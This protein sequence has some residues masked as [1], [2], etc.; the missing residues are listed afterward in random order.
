MPTSATD[1]TELSA[2]AEL[3]RRFFLEEVSPHEGEHAE[4]GHPDRSLYR[5]AGELGLL[6]MSIPEQFGGGGGDFGHLALL[7]HEQITSGVTSLGL[8]ITEGI[9][10]HYLL[11]YATEEQKQ[12]WLPRLCSGQWVGSIAMTEPGT[13]SDLQAI[14]TRARLVGDEYLV[15]GA[16]TFITNGWLCDLV[17]IV[18]RT[19]ADTGASGISLLVAEISEDTPGFRRGRLLKKVG[20]KGQDTAELFFDG[21][22]IPAANMLGGVPGMGFYQLMEQLPQERLLTAI[23]AQAMTEKAVEA[24]VEYTKTRHAFGKPL[25]AMQNTRF[26]LAECATIARV[27]R[28][29]LD[30]CIGLQRTGTL[31]AV[32]ASMAKYWVTDRAAE[33][34]DR[35]QQ[36]F[37]GYGYCL[38]YPIAHLYADNRILRVLAGAN[39]VMKELI[40]RSL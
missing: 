15:S 3:A 23:I 10:A 31:D 18:A 1:G 4:Q 36:L 17:I 34:I 24:A 22:R 7:I 39:E 35:C 19:G 25:F 12:R 14:A 26:E 8:A 21:L 11:A 32:T 27:N 30:Q 29:F 37:G 33:V 5:R 28:C 20:Q 6:G 2:V 16:K 40:A 13:G 9:V 38:E